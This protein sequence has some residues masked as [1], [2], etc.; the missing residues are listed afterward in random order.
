MAQEAPLDLALPAE[1][2]SVSVVRRAVCRRLLDWGLPDLVDP[3][4]LAASELATNAVLHARGVL[5]VTLRR[6]GEAAR[7]E[8]ADDSPRLP[9][10]R[11]HSA[12]SGT[13]RGLGLVAALSREWGVEPEGSGGKVVWAVFSTER[14]IGADWAERD[15]LADL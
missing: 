14:P 5:R 3:V 13:G 8:V 10:Q 7:L 4:A 1:P 11:R 15:W 6:D 9:Q 12:L 2:A